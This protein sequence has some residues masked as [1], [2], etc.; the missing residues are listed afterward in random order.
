M[1]KKSSKYG[2]RAVT[3]RIEDIARGAAASVVR[4]GR[5]KQADRV[6]QVSRDAPKPP[7]VRLRLLQVPPRRNRAATMA[8]A[9]GPAQRQGESKAKGVAIATGVRAQ[10]VSDAT[11]ARAKVAVAINVRHR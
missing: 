8:S 5:V 7:V 2:V 1:N 3:D 10:K 9:I 6:K 11:G 4:A